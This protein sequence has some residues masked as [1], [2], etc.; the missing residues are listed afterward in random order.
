MENTQLPSTDTEL[1]GF[2]QLL[3]REWLQALILIAPFV[4]IPFVW[5]SLPDY[6]PTH[7]NMRGHVNGYMGKFWGTFLLPLMNIV[8]ALLPIF[9]PKIDPK[10]QIG[11]SMRVIRILRLTISGFLLILF[12]LT[13]EISLGKEIDMSLITNLGLPVL[14]LVIGNYLPTVRPNYFIGVRVPWTLEDPENWRMTH[15]FTGKLY[16]IS[17]VLVIPC[18][19]LLPNYVKHYFFLTYL[20]IIVFPPM[21]Y[22]YLFYRNSIKQL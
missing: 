15:K 17:S 5:N 1:K 10:K 9:L 11:S 13:I 22:S 7:W 8:L 18:M 21:L 3:K 2:V 20:V 12:M 4:V 6:I 19:L 14:I 16:V